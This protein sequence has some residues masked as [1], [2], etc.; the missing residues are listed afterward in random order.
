MTSIYVPRNLQSNNAIEETRQN[1]RKLNRRVQESLNDI[2]NQMNDTRKKLG[3][4]EEQQAVVKSMLSHVIK[5]LQKR[6][7][8]N[9]ASETIITP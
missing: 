2:Q 8:E 5:E 6:S 3:Q 9:P 4:M 7:E 1:V